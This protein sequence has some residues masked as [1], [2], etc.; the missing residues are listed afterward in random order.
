M[1]K[2]NSWKDELTAAL[3]LLGHRNWIVVAD[4]AYPLQTQPGI[5]TLYVDDSYTDILAH[6]H[7]EITAAP[8]IKAAVYLDKE[9]GFLDEKDVPGIDTLRGKMKAIFGDQAQS[10]LHDEMIARLDQASRMFNVLLL[11]SSLTIPYTTT[12]FELDCAYWDA[13]REKTLRKK[14]A[15]S[16]KK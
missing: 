8:H 16:G 7:K 3:P 10:I 6:V 13:A 4:M 5:K 12:F 11:K 15:A 2:I 14:L 9:L 1:A